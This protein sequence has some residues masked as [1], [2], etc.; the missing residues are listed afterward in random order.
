MIYFQQTRGSISTPFSE[1]KV[2]FDFQVI[3]IYSGI[4]MG[5]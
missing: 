3:A 5:E 1:N 4:R 2:I